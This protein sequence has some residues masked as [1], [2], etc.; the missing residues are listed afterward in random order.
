[1]NVEQSSI[2]DKVRSRALAFAENAE[3]SD[4][5][6]EA[7]DPYAKAGFLRAFGNASSEYSRLESALII[8]PSDCNQYTDR[9]IPERLGL[10]ILT[11]IDSIF[12]IDRDFSPIDPEITKGMERVAHASNKKVFIVHGHDDALREKVARF[13]EKAALEPIILAE[14]PGGGAT[15]IEKL[16]ANSDVAFSIVLLT[17]DDVGGKSAD[18]LQ[19]RARQN[20]VFELGYFVGLITRKRV[21]AL[22]DPGVEIFS[23]ITGVNYVE[24]DVAGAWKT[25]LLK[26]LQHAGFSPDLNALL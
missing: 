5:D 21:C 4:D 19:P 23:D 13:I 8:Y 20:V 11:L 9:L 25:Q 26:E 16:E 14:Q 10:R 2:L 6:I 17:Q 12:E 15:I 3:V 22:V 1:M 7:F 18:N 24:A